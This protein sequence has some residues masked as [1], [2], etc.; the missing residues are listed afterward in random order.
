[1]ITGEG[2]GDGATATAT[3][4]AGWRDYMVT[5]EGWAVVVRH[6]ALK[7]FASG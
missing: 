4:S 6:V 5:S 7:Y 2:L 1:M 3:A